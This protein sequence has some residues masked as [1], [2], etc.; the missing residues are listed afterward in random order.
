VAILHRIAKSGKVG[1]Q[2]AH[3]RAFLLLARPEWSCPI[4]LRIGPKNIRKELTPL[5]SVASGAT[6][7]LGKGAINCGGA[8]TFPLSGSEHNLSIQP[9]A[10]GGHNLQPR[11]GWTPSP[12]NPVNLLNPLNLHALQGVSNG[13]TFPSGPLAPGPSILRTLSFLQFLSSHPFT[14]LL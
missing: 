8:A 13:D 7:F 1:P 3:K 5:S 11:R 9:A 14:F 10:A 12:L 6:P 4:G 2:P